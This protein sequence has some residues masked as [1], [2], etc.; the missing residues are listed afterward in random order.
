MPSLKGQ[1]M[2]STI[3]L[4]GTYGSAPNKMVRLRW[5]AVPAAIW[6]ALAILFAT[7]SSSVS[8]PQYFFLTQDVP[9]AALMIGFLMLVR[10]QNEAIT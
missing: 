5:F 8:Q 2:A 1:E 6:M 3:C 9:V 10:W 7:S 4:S